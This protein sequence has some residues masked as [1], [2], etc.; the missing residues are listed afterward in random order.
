[1]RRKQSRFRWTAGSAGWRS[2][3]GPPEERQARL[4]ACGLGV[5]EQLLRRTALE[6]LAVRHGIRPSERTAMAMLR[7]VSVDVDRARQLLDEIVVQT[8]P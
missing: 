2:S 7:Q 5:A 1:M 8:R 3:W 6:Q 4:Q